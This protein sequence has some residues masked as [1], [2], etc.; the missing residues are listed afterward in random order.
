MVISAALD[1]FFPLKSRIL[2]G[3]TV[4]NMPIMFMYLEL[5]VAPVVQ[6]V[7]SKPSDVRTRVR[8][9]VSSHELGFFLT[10]KINE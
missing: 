9:L 6:L 2:T 3:H 5:P 4:K 1:L 8:I 7:T 10:Q